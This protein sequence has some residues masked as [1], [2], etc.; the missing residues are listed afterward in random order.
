MLALV[1]VHTAWLFTHGPSRCHRKHRLSLTWIIFAGDLRLER[2]SKTSCLQQV[3][4]G[5]TI[6]RSCPFVAVCR[7]LVVFMVFD[8]RY[9][10]NQVTNIPELPLWSQLNCMFYASYWC[11][12]A[13]TVLDHYLYIHEIAKTIGATPVRGIRLVSDCGWDR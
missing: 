2:D 9:S 5:L 6:L 4:S 10:S 13:Q 11:S 1:L 7:I 3:V 8:I 12:V